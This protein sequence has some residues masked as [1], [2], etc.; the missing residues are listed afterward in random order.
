MKFYFQFLFLS[1][2]YYY[3][4]FITY[5]E[6]YFQWILCIHYWENVEYEGQNLFFPKFSQS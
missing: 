1:I 2:A 6:R 4:K 5:I 3:G